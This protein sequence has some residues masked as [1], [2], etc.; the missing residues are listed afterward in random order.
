[1]ARKGGRLSAFQCLATGMYRPVEKLGKVGNTVYGKNRHGQTCYALVIPTNPRTAP[2]QANRHLFGALGPGWSRLTDKQRALWQADA[3]NH[4]THGRPGRHA[5]LTGF[6]R[7]MQV[8]APRARQG[9]ALLDVPPS[10]FSIHPS[11]FPSGPSPRLPHRSYPP[12]VPMLCRS[13]TVA[14]RCRHAWLP[15]G[16]APPVHRVRPMTLCSRVCAIDVRAGGFIGAP[17]GKALWC[18]HGGPAARRIGAFPVCA[19][20]AAA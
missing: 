5:P 20:W 2:Q 13:N 7:F 15:L 11:S 18:G 12:R 19:L 9:L 1:M 8:N 16:P 14:T 4:R 6:Q 3:R 10:S 17:G